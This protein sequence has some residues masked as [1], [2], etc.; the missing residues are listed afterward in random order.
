VL[1]NK[2]I[3]V[4]LL[5]ILLISMLS[6]CTNTG[7]SPTPSGSS[8]VPPVGI[9][10]TISTG[11]PVTV[12]TGTISQTG[13][14]IK[15]TESGNPLTGL[16][17]NIPAN[18]Y[19]D[20]R[21]IKISYAPIEKH[22]FG[23]N[24]NP[25]T[26][27]ITIENCGGYSNEFISIKVP[28]HIPEGHFA[29][30]FLY[31]NEAKKLEGLPVLSHDVDSI[32]IATMHL[33]SL[34][35]SDIDEALL[36]ADIDSKFMPGLDDWEFENGG[37]YIAPG[38]H[39]AGQSIS[40]LWYYYEKPDGASARLFGR[41][42]N[43]GNK[44]ATPGFDSDDS[45]CYRLASV[46]QSDINWSSK[47]NRF[48]SLQRGLN[49]ELTWKYFAYSMLLT[50]QPQLVSLL[51]GENG[52]AMIVYRVVKGTLYVADPNY[53][54]NTSRK[55][56]YNNGKFTP[57]NSGMNADDIKAGRAVS[58]NKIGFRAKTAAVD[59]TKIQQRWNE[60][61]SESKSIGND[62]FPLYSLWYGDKDIPNE[63]KDNNETTRPY[64]G[65]G[66]KS[67]KADIKVTVYRE[68]MEAKPD[69]DGLFQLKP[70]NNRF[71]VRID[72]KV[73][74][75]YEYIDFKYVNINYKSQTSPTITGKLVYK[76][77]G[78]PVVNNIT[79]PSA[80]GVSATISADS[81][82]YTNP[83]PTVI[84]ATQ[85]AV[86]TPPIT[87]EPG[88]SNE[89]SFKSSVAVAKADKITIHVPKTGVEPWQQAR[90][91]ETY[92]TDLANPFF[93][94]IT[95]FSVSPSTV[96]V[97]DMLQYSP[98][99][100]KTWKT[101][102]SSDEAWQKYYEP[103][104]KQ[105]L[106]PILVWS[107]HVGNYLPPS[108]SKPLP[109]S[110]SPEESFLQFRIKPD[111]TGPWPDKIVIVFLAEATG[112]PGGGGNSVATAVYTYQKQ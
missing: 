78:S 91:S 110:T 67:N 76:L 87:F 105:V 35:V 40:A 36:N 83:D 82:T 34:V 56:E 31:N 24:F 101:P 90:D 103:G 5:V 43:N 41:Y 39:C 84:K 50:G 104:M 29:M 9:F 38:G 112:L 33:Y 7:N 71:G 97:A 111:Y 49:D 15:V 58:F 53:P 61:K 30:A 19:S 28:I 93:R 73:D 108:T 45:L 59:W 106:Q 11:A 79:K 16:E 22:T 8:A 27:L 12:A 54:G 3:V 26:P 66:G 96:R 107:K 102:V 70:G 74:K 81:A 68:G 100:G 17:L 98:D 92:P 52:H 46:V 62:K 80:S 69:K 55:I 18:S 37:S 10:G 63:L 109:L 99:N 2:N 86:W 48:W 89:I 72:G 25:I 47:D 1:K 94:I 57:Y 95:T 64:I 85:T 65:I 51:A 20:T 77:Q 44:P 23:K 6:A 4:L 14:A 75:E 21:Q 13:G 60:V 32:A 42:D 88:Q